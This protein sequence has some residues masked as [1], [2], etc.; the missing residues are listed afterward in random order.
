MFKVLKLRTQIIAIDSSKYLSFPDIVKSPKA[1][2][3]FFL[4]YREGETHH[5]TWSKL[6]LLR[7]DDDGVTWNFQ[8]EFYIDIKKDKYV[9]NCP[10]LSY[11][12]DM[13]YITCDQKSSIFEQSAQF[14]TVNLISKTEGEFFELQATPIIGMVPDKIIKFKDKLLCAN[15]KI[16]SLKN[17]LIQLVT[18]SRD[19]GKTW[20]DTNIMAHSLTRYFCEASIVNMGDYVIAY[21][22]EN[23]GHKR[24]IYTVKSIDGIH[25]SEPNKLPIF[26]QRVT[27][28]REGDK[29][30]GTYRDIDIPLSCKDVDIPL[31]YTDGK[32]NVSIFEHDINNNKIDIDYIDWEYPENQYHFGY[33]GIAK[34]SKDLY[35]VTYYIRQKNAMPFIKLVFVKKIKE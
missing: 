12:D 28:I 22:R 18:W 27:A 9:W 11:I 26:G 17:D 34:V 25:W 14:K 7:T 3:R 10:R 23:S 33:T 29:T 13:L 35:M 1:D 24:N 32:Y 30:I 31:I 15:H 19:N 8:N 16:K 6:V 2:G 4:V 20:Y 21:L 5:P